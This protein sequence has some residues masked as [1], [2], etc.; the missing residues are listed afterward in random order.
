MNIFIMMSLLA[1][2][3]YI[4]YIFVRK[5]LCKWTSYHY[6]RYKINKNKIPFINTQYYILEALKLKNG[7]YRVSI[8]TKDGK[9]VYNITM[10]INVNPFAI[11]FYTNI[12]TNTFRLLDIHKEDIIYIYFHDIKS[13]LGTFL[14]TFN[15]QH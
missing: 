9:W 8:Q 6:Q 1:P 7:G 13:P 14:S 5:P 3:L 2:L 10:L 11:Q 15:V 12:F 4:T